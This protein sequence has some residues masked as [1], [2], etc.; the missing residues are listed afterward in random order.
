MPKE[1]YIQLNKLVFDKNLGDSIYI[2]FITK[3]DQY[4]T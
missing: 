3:K 1:F 4:L 2:K